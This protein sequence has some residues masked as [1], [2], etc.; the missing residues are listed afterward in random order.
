MTVAT[1]EGIEPPSSVLETDVM[2]L[3]HTVMRKDCGTVSCLRRQ[4]WFNQP[5]LSYQLSLVVP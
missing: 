2:P 3:Y 5:L 1:V 4:C